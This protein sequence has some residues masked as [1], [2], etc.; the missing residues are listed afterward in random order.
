MKQYW[1]IP[2]VLFLLM[3]VVEIVAVTLGYENIH[4]Y[5]KP[6]LIPVLA[7]A[8]GLYLH[9]HKAPGAAII[10]L[11]ASLVGHTLGDIFLL[12]DSFSFF[13]CGI[14]AFMVGHIL[15]IVILR[16]L[17]NQSAT[18]FPIG[19][20]IADWSVSIAIPLTMAIMLPQSHIWMTIL[21]SGYAFVLLSV[22][23][24]SGRCITARIPGSKA[25]LAGITLFIISDS[26]LAMHQFLGIEFAFRHAAVMGTYLIAQG[27]IVSGLC[28]S[29]QK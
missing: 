9:S 26:M 20:Q 2:G 5:L 1:K 17:L 7:I 4:F 13:I 27:L 29:L 6:Y 24:L 22:A 14:A 25:A 10:I 16:K 11:M 21:I 18:S 8:A 23:R 12:S 15:Y 3:T 28:R 19:R